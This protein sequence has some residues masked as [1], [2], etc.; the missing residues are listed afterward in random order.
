[1][2]LEIHHDGVHGRIAC[3]DA[4]ERGIEEFVGRWT[5]ALERQ[6]SG[7]GSAL[8]A[9]DA[10]R[11]RAELLEAVQRNPGVRRLAANPLLLTILALMKRQGVNFRHAVELLNA[12]APSSKKWTTRLRWSGFE[13]LIGSRN[14]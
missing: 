7:A 1:V 5:E 10:V 8:A 12:V 9:A 13:V 4:L 11:E 14:S 2:R 6:A 3:R